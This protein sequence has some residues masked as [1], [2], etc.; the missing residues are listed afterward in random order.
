MASCFYK[1]IR[2]ETT[3]CSGMWSD[4]VLSDYYW[5]RGGKNIFVFFKE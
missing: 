2:N 5:D 3:L 4:Q 1:K